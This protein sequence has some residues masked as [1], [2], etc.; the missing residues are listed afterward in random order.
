MATGNKLVKEI[1]DQFLHCKI[2][3]E[4]YK[5]PKTL[6]C[7]HTF[8]ADCIQKH[9]D[10]DSNRSSR[11]LLYSRFITCPLCRSKT[12][13]PTGG[14][15]RLP[16][17]FLV[18]SLTDV[19]DR[20]KIGKVPPCEICPG[21]RQRAHN[22]ASH[23][24]LDCAKLLCK[25]CVNLHTT[26]KVTQHHSLID[27]EGEKDIECKTHPEEIVRY[28]CE[29]CEEC[30]CV[31]CTFQE[32]RDHE[33]CS[34]SDGFSKY[35]NGLDALLDRCKVRLSDVE[36]R[37]SNIN[38]VE[39]TLKET[40]ENIRDLAI[41]YI[42]QVRQ[43]E[44]QL[45]QRV[46]EDFGTK[47]QGYIQNKE[48]L[49]ENY[50]NLKTTCN[51]AEIIMN[52]RGVEM[53]LL[54]KEL[55]NKLSALLEPTLPAVPENVSSSIKFVPGN[56]KLGHISWKSEEETD[57]D[58]G[59]VKHQLPE[60]DDPPRK[61]Q[62]VSRDTQTESS[63]TLPPLSSEINFEAPIT[64]N[65]HRT[66]FINGFDQNDI[67]K[68]LDKE[69]SSSKTD[70]SVN[71]MCS[72]DE[73]KM[74]SVCVKCCAELKKEYGSSS[75]LPV[76]DGTPPAIQ[77]IIITNCSNGEKDRQGRRRRS[78][79]KSRRVQTDISLSNESLDDTLNAS[80]ESLNN[81]FRKLSQNSLTAVAECVITTSIGLDPIDFGPKEPASYKPRI[82]TRN[83]SVNTTQNVRII[84]DSRSVRTNTDV[85]D[86]RD[87]TTMTYP[88]SIS[89]DTQTIDKIS[90]HKAIAT[91]YTGQRN[92]R[93]STP[94]IITMDSSTHMPPL[95]QESKVTWTENVQT[96]E[97][98]V[99]TEMSETAE[100]STETMQPT[101]SD[102]STDVKPEMKTMEIN[103]DPVQFADSVD[104]SASGAKPK[105]RKSKTKEKEKKEKE[106]KE[107]SADKKT[108]EKKERK[109]KK[110]YTDSCVE[111]DPVLR[112]DKE[113]G[114]VIAQFKDSWT[115]T[116]TPQLVNTGISPARPATREAS[117]ATNPVVLMEQ[118]TYTDVVKQQDSTTETIIATCEGETLTERIGQQDAQTEVDLFL[119]SV[120]TITDEC[121]VIETGCM[122]DAE[123][124]WNSDRELNVVV[125][126][127]CQERRAFVDTATSPI[128]IANSESMRKG[129]SLVNHETQTVKIKLY[130][131]SNMTS[132]D[133]DDI[134]EQLKG[135]NNCDVSTSTENLPY[136]G[137]LSDMDCDELILV[138]EIAIDLIGSDAEYQKIYSNSFHMDVSETSAQTIISS[139]T[140]NIDMLLSCDPEHA[141]DLF[142]PC[143]L[144]NVGVNTEHALTFEKETCT[145]SLH[146]LSKGTNTLQQS[147]KVDKSTSTGSFVKNMQ[148]NFGQSPPVQ[149]SSKVQ[150]S[151]KKDVSVETDSSLM[152]EKMI[153][154]INK[155]KTVS[156]RLNSPTSKM[157]AETLPWKDN[158]ENPDT[159]LKEL[160][161]VTEAERKKNVM[162]LVAKSQAI[163]RPKETK[164]TKTE[165]VRRK[166][167][168]LTTLKTKYQEKAAENDKKPNTQR[169][170]SS[171][172]ATSVPA[173]KNGNQTPS[174]QRK[175]P[176]S[177]RNNSA[178]G[179]IATVPNQAALRKTSPTTQ[180]KS[181]GNKAT[182]VKQDGAA[183]LPAPTPKQSQEP[184]FYSTVPK[185]R[186]PKHGLA[187]ISEHRHSSG[188]D[189]S[190]TSYRSAVSEQQN[191]ST[192]SLDKSLDFSSLKINAPP[193]APSASPTPTRHPTK[194][195]NGRAAR[196][197]TTLPKT[198][199][200]VIPPVDDT[201][202]TTRA[203]T[204]STSSDQTDNEPS[205]EK[206]GFIK[207][208]FGS[209]KKKSSDKRN[210]SP[211][212]SPKPGR[213]AIEVA[214]EP[215]PESPKEK[216][217]EKPKPFVY[218][219][220]RFFPIE[221]KDEDKY[222]KPIVNKYC[223]NK[224]ED[225]KPPMFDF[226][227]T[228]TKKK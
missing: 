197:K 40:R 210:A 23:K 134:P 15:R 103:T 201:S 6:T 180:P 57:C 163:T 220:G 35:K 73:N 141:M 8:C 86:S 112:S 54:K 149:R 31:V 183:T 53:L 179:R 148:E 25:T 144:I 34:F 150:K 85:A 48:W 44:R 223:I 20:K 84:P 192:S 101:F 125:C 175:T 147:E 11:F 38:C 21:E 196:P 221:Q 1:T 114:T 127:V 88:D 111:T 26:T 161:K 191:T 128:D 160:D 164:E 51:L 189:M 4:P 63:S 24:C 92:K 93:T 117:V 188:S 137:L 217:K 139:E 182:T 46:E 119:Q 174:T 49:Q 13:I 159:V 72:V 212:K 110:K 66:P 200:E 130:D 56:V 138:P 77:D 79:I 91:D 208:L 153:A 132:C 59:S 133:F 195:D 105:E 39:S 78:L 152:D 104:A 67:K 106:K 100:S 178:P 47:I 19:L 18:S 169:R 142:K 118:A 102:Q 155:L 5:D 99:C 120:E 14:V 81:S 28:Y 45:M 168:P 131:K 96:T 126:D 172:S 214:P 170:D 209:K 68:N 71:T 55:Q 50:E 124:F 2:C 218:M 198:R 16:D 157:F 156:E 90:A 41:S 113:T 36:N 202:D 42:S 89:R 203:R 176:T 216:P 205:Q 94:I 33:I 199:I 7:L 219:R 27:I 145:P 165:P 190:S 17:N 222:N 162:D 226:A 43:T 65:S 95:T 186:H 109:E 129:V 140:S 225:E 185:T 58:G 116:F 123:W 22:H 60:V 9:V 80:Q 76:I 10:S 74:G 32:H 194:H 107:K 173:T 146:Q 181:N 87:S 122:T 115:E 213:K 29:P 62:C 61:K 97:R 75:S 83:K 204:G 98:S 227:A 82:F 171:D 30:I 70:V 224:E 177:K 12:E 69:A 166:A 151:V 136:I 207:K 3:Y 143:N 206:K 64:N 187:S 154:C 215:P 211:S 37:L 108:K 167:Q 228:F 52:D 135:L 158:P 184:E 193:R 121:Y